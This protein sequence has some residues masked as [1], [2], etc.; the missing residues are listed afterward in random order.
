MSPAVALIAA[1]IST[2]QLMLTADGVAGRFLASDGV[3]LEF[4]LRVDPDGKLD[5]LITHDLAEVVA[6]VADRTTLVGLRLEAMQSPLWNAVRELAVALAKE[7]GAEKVASLLK[8]AI[9]SADRLRARA[10]EVD[11]GGDQKAGEPGVHVELVEDVRRPLDQV[12]ALQKPRD[13]R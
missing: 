6:A 9:A 2:P 8:Q 1:L 4:D 7:T 13:V 12:S 5:L 11:A 10:G 3:T